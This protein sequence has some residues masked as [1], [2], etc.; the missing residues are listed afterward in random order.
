MSI[1]RITLTEPLPG[2]GSVE[3][4]PTVD[5]EPWC[6]CAVR[7]ASDPDDAIV[8]GRVWGDGDTWCCRLAGVSTGSVHSTQQ[9]AT[10]ALVARWCAGQGVHPLDT[11]RIG[12]E[13]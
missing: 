11:D 10:A 12:S 9:A 3:L 7:P 4:W 2:V 8:I 6:W 1:T 13:P 5:P